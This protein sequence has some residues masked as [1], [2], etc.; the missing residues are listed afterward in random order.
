MNNNQNPSDMKKWFRRIVSTCLIAVLI[1]SSILPQFDHIYQAQT[2]ENDSAESNAVVEEETVD[3]N[4]SQE[5]PE[6]NMVQEDQTEQD[7]QGSSTAQDSV[8]QSPQ[9]NPID[10]QIQEQGQPANVLKA[11]NTEQRKEQEEKQKADAQQKISPELSVTLTAQ[12]DFPK[13]AVGKINAL[14][15]EGLDNLKKSLNIY[16]EK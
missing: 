6:T 1:H 7:S 11:D 4:H 10:Q 9:E 3:G 13:N 14:E 5:D 2:E 16:L 15:G 12:T 8:T